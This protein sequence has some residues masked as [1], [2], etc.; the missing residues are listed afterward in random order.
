MAGGHLERAS[1]PGAGGCRSG[2]R[3]RR[4]L[5]GES[6]RR[7]QHER[8]KNNPQAPTTE[9]RESR[10]ALA[11]FYSQFSILISFSV[12]RHRNT[13]LFF[14]KPSVVRGVAKHALDVAPRFGKWDAFDPIFDVHRATLGDPGSSSPRSR[15]VSRRR[16]LD[17]SELSDHLREVVHSELDIE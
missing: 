2:W 12:C 17:S 8:E 3:A 4:S 10:I 7:D 5:R 15:V 6:D 1:C 11:I 13:L 16:V 9:N 14:V